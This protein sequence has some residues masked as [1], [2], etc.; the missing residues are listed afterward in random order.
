MHSSA[1]DYLKPTD[2]Q[3]AE[4][5]LVRRATRSYCEFLENALPDGPDKTYILRKVRE[6]GMW[7]NVAITRHADGTPR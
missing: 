6:A 5:E 1:F 4:M 2:Q 3:I 7:A